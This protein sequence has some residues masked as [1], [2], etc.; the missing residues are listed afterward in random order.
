MRGRLDAC[1]PPFL[2]PEILR[3][4][5]LLSL[6]EYFLMTRSDTLSIPGSC[7]YACALHPRPHAR[8]IP[9]DDFTEAHER[10]GGVFVHC[11]GFGPASYRHCRCRASDILPHC[12][13]LYSSVSPHGARHSL[14]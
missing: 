9:C 1:A 10:K 2:Q 8:E 5:L 12:S 6:W 3:L 11:A 4:C 7:P 13:P 14:E